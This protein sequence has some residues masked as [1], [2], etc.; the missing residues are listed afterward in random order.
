MIRTRQ[1]RAVFDNGM[2]VNG[3]GHYPSV[4]CVE[5]AREDWRSCGSVIS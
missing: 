2:S 5:N 3:Y 4:G 1:D